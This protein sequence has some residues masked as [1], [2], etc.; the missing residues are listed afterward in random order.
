MLYRAKQVQNNTI[1]NIYLTDMSPSDYRTVFIQNLKKK[2]KDTHG[3]HFCS[4]EVSSGL[5]QM[6]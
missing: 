4:S 5:T 1:S 6:A 2:K 3:C